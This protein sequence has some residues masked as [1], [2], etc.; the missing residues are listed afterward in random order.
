MAARAEAEAA[1]RWA[2]YGEDV[3]PD[4]DVMP[5]ADEESADEDDAHV[6]PAACTFAKP[7]GQRYSVQQGHAVCVTHRRAMLS[8]GGVTAAV[9]AEGPCAAMQGWQMLQS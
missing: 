7:P 9:P 2:R 5:D 1:H 4:E 6:R 3:G 8:Q